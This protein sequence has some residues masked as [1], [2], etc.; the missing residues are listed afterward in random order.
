MSRV[1][2][3]V[4]HNLC[5]PL[6]P[7]TNPWMPRRADE[8]L[9][10]FKDKFRCELTPY[11]NGHILEIGAGNGILAEGLRNAGCRRITASDYWE[12]FPEFVNRCV[13]DKHGLEFIRADARRL[14]FA[15]QTF[16][17]VLSEDGFEH[18]LN[19]EE[20]LTEA[21]RV[22]RDGGALLV[23]FGPPWF[24]PRGGHMMFLNAP[25]WFHLIFSDNTIFNVRARYRSDGVHDWSSGY[26]PLNKLT[27]GQFRRA[28]RAMGFVRREETWWPIRGLT[29][30][31]AIPFLREF[32]C[33]LYAGI[34]QK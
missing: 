18:F 22:L 27:M 11:L 25:P 12:K 1:G 16:D 32:C 29:M 24:S 4:L 26:S 15:N 13:V 7:D 9:A 19:P 8:Q 6:P 30:L 34:W 31:T 17:T 2:Q 21:F 3:W 20:V 28:A 33:N 5:R 23:T 10:G 14:P